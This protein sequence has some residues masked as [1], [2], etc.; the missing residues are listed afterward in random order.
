M[1][2]RGNMLISVGGRPIFPKVFQRV[3]W[4]PP[5]FSIRT[6][7]A[8]PPAIE[9][10]ISPVTPAHGRWH[11]HVLMPVVFRPADKQGH[12][13]MPM[14]P[15]ARWLAEGDTINLTLNKRIQ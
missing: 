11:G 14:P 12:E 10:Q 7:R 9:R 8:S 15:I 4:K 3:S 1:Q 2:T 13:Y 6:R 5:A